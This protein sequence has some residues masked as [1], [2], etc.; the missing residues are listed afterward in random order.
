MGFE[1][2]QIK[3]PVAAVIVTKNEGSQLER[4]LE[5]LGDFAEVFIVDTPSSSSETIKALAEKYEAEYV[6]FEWNGKYPKK[7]QWSLDHLDFTCDWVLFV[8]ADEMITPALLEEIKRLD[9][10]RAGYFIRGAY[11]W[12]G[13][14]LKHGLKNN[15]LCLIDRRKIE[16]PVVDDLGFPGMGE[17]EGHYQPVLKRENRMEML[18]QLKH[19]L[20]HFAYKDFDRWEDRH[21]EYASWVAAMDR[22]DAWPD[23]PTLL[24]GLAKAIFRHVP[25]RPLCALIYSYVFKLG[26]LDGHAGYEFAKS[27]SWYYRRIASASKGRGRARASSRRRSVL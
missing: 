3:I 20:V 4:S 21:R 9:F 12:D 10:K 2:V 17:I 15:K 8:D 27:R 6:V 23:E 1:D 11:E 18:G 5:K 25:F 24:R 22:H 7:R 13:E 26:F 14:I 19:P 16:F